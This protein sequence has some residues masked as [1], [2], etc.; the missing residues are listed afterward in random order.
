MKQRSHHNSTVLRLL[1][2]WCG[3][4]LYMGAFSPIGMGVA[5]ILGTIDPDHHAI[6]QP[7]SDGMRLVL[8]HQGKCS[9]HKHHAVARALSFFA[10]PA[11][12]NNPDHVVQFGAGNGVWRN[13]QLVV[14]SED[15]V[16]QSAAVVELC[17]FTARV[18]PTR[19][20]PPPGPPPDIVGNLLNVR[21][22][23]F[24]I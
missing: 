11:S 16:D 19:L 20:L 10:Q 15:S 9:E 21:S 6:L 2:G 12:E 1:A 14:L 18:Q 7:G 23:V 22:T 8:H 13:S 17:V 3:V 24:L 4:L 5:A